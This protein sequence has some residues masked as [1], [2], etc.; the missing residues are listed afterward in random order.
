MEKDRF[1]VEVEDLAKSRLKKAM[2]EGRA[3]MIDRSRACLCQRE[4][5]CLQ[6]IL[7]N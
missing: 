2:A 7:S 5:I 6:S 1:E 3:L 4:K